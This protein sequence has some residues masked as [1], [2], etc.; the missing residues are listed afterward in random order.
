MRAAQPCRLS[1]WGAVEL[2][3]QRDTTPA[4]GRPTLGALRSGRLRAIH[5]ESLKLSRAANWTVTL[6]LQRWVP[7]LPALLAGL[8]LATQ[9][10]S[11]GRASMCEAEEWGALSCGRALTAIDCDPRHIRY[12][13]TA[14]TKQSPTQAW[15]PRSLATLAHQRRHARP[16]PR[17]D[18]SQR[19]GLKSASIPA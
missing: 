2:P 13:G 8:P 6:E 17:Q 14:S 18:A 5:K 10:L 15:P 7:S 9:A 12:Y 4:R 19:W 16:R 1:A 11:C 3:S